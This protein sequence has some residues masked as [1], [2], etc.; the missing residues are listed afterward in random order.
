MLYAI[1]ARKKISAHPIALFSLKNCK[2]RP[3]PPDPLLLRLTPH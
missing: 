3:V 1:F 2:N